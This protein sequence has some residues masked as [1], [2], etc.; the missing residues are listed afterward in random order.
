M[1]CFVLRNKMRLKSRCNKSREFSVA[2]ERL[3]C[4]IWQLLWSLQWVAGVSQCTRVSAALDWLFRCFSSFV[5]K[6]L[7]MR[8]EQLCS[9]SSVMTSQISGWHDLVTSSH[10]WS[11]LCCPFRIVQIVV[12]Y[13][14]GV[15]WFWFTFWTSSCQLVPLALKSSIWSVSLILIRSFAESWLSADLTC[16]MIL[17][18]TQ[19][20]TILR[21]M[22]VKGFSTLKLKGLS[23][24]CRAWWVQAVIL[25]LAKSF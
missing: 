4:W 14:G 8:W 7:M 9:N 12:R 10:C 18:D 25:S 1:W 11:R 5:K 13:F 15:P 6:C 21:L 22:K 23:C 2:S 16:D 20:R 3:S 17:F 24:P 19:Q